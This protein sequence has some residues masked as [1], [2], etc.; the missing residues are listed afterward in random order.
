MSRRRRQQLSPTLFP[1]LAVLVCTLGTLILLLALVAQNAT[2]AVAESTTEEP[3]D[4]Q[5][6]S[7]NAETLITEAGFRVEHLVSI[8]DQQVEDIENRRDQ[9][10]HLDDH[11]TRVKKQLEHL[12]EEIKMAKGRA[13]TESIDEETLK[14]FQEQIEIE[15]AKLEALKA[16]KAS[17]TPRI[18]IVPHKGPNGTDRRPVYLECTADGLTVWPEGVQIDPTNLENAIGEA[19]PLD[20]ALRAVRHHALQNYGDTVAPYPLIV[21]RPDGI[22]TYAAARHAMSDWDDQFGYELVP[23][24][25]DLAYA[26]PDPRLESRLKEVISKANQNQRKFQSIAG[27]LTAGAGVIGVNRSSSSGTSRM[28]TL[29]AASMDRNGRASGYRDH[30]DPNGFGSAKVWA[31]NQTTYGGTQPNLGAGTGSDAA[32][33]LDQRLK[34][35]AGEIGNNSGFPNPGIAGEGIAGEGIAGEGDRK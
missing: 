9:L 5:L 3:S 24:E 26:R 2:T 32:R 19:N 25:V 15:K 20:A 33:K 27:R 22:A 6:T 35:A 28:P 18:V 16:E 1:F 4:N 34:S 10:A 21:V 30:R 12:N 31:Q 29:S 14:Q 11:I 13:P 23:A 7:A 17:K 8:R